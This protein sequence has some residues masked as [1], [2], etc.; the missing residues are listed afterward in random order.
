MNGCRDGWSAPTLKRRPRS[1]LNE[2]VQN[3]KG[4]LYME[5]LL[6]GIVA[7]GLLAYLV[8]ALIKPEI[9]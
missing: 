5:N 9:F 6:V 3:S 8:V 7:V 4:K 1:R 2:K